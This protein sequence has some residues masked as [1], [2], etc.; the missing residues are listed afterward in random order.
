MLSLGIVLMSATPASAQLTV[1]RTPAGAPDLGR[2]IAGSATTTLAIS[3]QGE[4]MRTAGDAIRLNGGSVTVPTISISCA[5]ADKADMCARRL[6]QVTIQPL[7]GSGRAAITMLRVAEL[8]GATFRDGTPPAAPAMTFV[9]NP[10]GSGTATFK[11]GM[12]VRLPARA[13]SGATVF[14]YSVTAVLL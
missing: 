14:D 8:T 3:P 2:M 1:S 13:A 6:L 5:Q 11:L 9:L 4:V 12:D 10:I 7:G